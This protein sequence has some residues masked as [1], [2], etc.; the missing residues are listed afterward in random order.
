MEKQKIMN[1]LRDNFKHYEIEFNNSYIRLGHWERG[2]NNFEKFLESVGYTLSII[3][4]EDRGN[5]YV[6]DKI[7]SGISLGDM[8]IAQT[9]FHEP[10]IKVKAVDISGSDEQNSGDV[11]FFGENG[12]TYYERDLLLITKI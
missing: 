2:D 7:V 9:N 5:L 11:V 1:Y 12:K 4:D 6:Y 10:Q 3:Q 8:Y